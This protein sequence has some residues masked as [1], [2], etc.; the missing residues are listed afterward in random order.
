MKFVALRALIILFIYLWRLAPPK[1]AA[2]RTRELLLSDKTQ[3]RTTV[4]SLQSNKISDR[5]LKELSSTSIP[6]LKKRLLRRREKRATQ[7]GS[8]TQ[9]EM[10]MRIVGLTFF[11]S[12]LS[13][14]GEKI[15]PLKIDDGYNSIELPQIL[16]GE[17]WLKFFVVIVNFP[18]KSRPPPH[19]IR[20]GGGRV[21]GIYELGA[22]IECA[23]QKRTLTVK[24]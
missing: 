10:N 6:H 9:F 7:K 23:A 12:G 4:I 13:K 3:G 15:K 11:S 8:V 17:K 22:Y 1:F 21:R 16:V 2:A 14:K 18:Y 5:K 19:P 20:W 24:T